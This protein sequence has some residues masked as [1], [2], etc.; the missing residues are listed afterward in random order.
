MADPEVPTVVSLSA[1][2]AQVTELGEQIGRLAEASDRSP[3]EAVAAALYDTERGL[4]AARRSLVRA[5]KAM[6]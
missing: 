1:L 6:A 4:R 5:E 3:T 2:T